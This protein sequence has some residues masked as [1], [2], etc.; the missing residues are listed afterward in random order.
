MHRYL[1]VLATIVV[2]LLA[3]LQPLRAGEPNPVAA[4]D[5]MLGPDATMIE[6]AKAANQRL[7]KSFPI[8]FALDETH[9]PTRTCLG[10]VHTAFIT[11]ARC[12]SGASRSTTQAGARRRSIQARLNFGPGRGLPFDAYSCQTARH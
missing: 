5:I 6:H 1:K 12:A 9:H 7:L 4:I 8:G 10:L 11:G 2:G 3:S